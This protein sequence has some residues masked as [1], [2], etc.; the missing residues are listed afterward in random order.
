MVIKS[1][2]NKQTRNLHLDGK[3]KGVP[4]D[5][6]RRA[7]MRLERIAAATGVDDLRVPPSH[8]LESLR[9]DREGQWS[10]RVNRQYRIC[11]VWRDG[12]AFEVDFCD[13]H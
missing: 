8:N 2:R 7:R 4:P 9:G 6:W 3:A 13:Y 11:F 12:H 5:L 1:Y 10:I